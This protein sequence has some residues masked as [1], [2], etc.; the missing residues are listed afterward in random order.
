MKLSM[1]Q[2]IRMQAHCI[3]G[4]P[5]FTAYSPGPSVVNTAFTYTYHATGVG[6]TYSISSGSVPPGLTLNAS[7][8][9]LSGTP[10]AS[11]NYSFII[12]ATNAYGFDESPQL[13]STALTAMV[14]F[15]P[16]AG[17]AAS[18]TINGYNGSITSQ[19]WYINFGSGPVL[20]P[21]ATA[22]TYTPVLTGGVGNGG[23]DVGGY[24][25]VRGVTPTGTFTSLEFNTLNS[26]IR[27]GATLNTATP[28]SGGASGGSAQA[29][30]TIGAPVTLRAYDNATKYYVDQVVAPGTYNAYSSL[31]AAGL[32]GAP[33]NSQSTNV[34]YSYRN[35]QGP[36]AVIAPKADT[37]AA[38]ATRPGFNTGTGF[39]VKAG[40]LYDPNGNRFRIRGVNQC[41]YDD[42]AQGLPIAKFNA[43]RMALYLTQPWTGGGYV[44]SLVM[45]NQVTNKIMPIPSTQ[46][47]WCRFTG[48]ISGNTLTVNSKSG[49]DFGS[50]V[51]T[52]SVA[53]AGGASAFT[54]TQYGTGT[55]G[56]GTYTISGSPQTT[57]TIQFTGTATTTGNQDPAYPLACAQAWIDQAANWTTFNGQMMLNLINEWG[58]DAGNTFQGSVNGNVL[59]VSGLN[60]AHKFIHTNMTVDT[61]GLPTFTVLSAI[62]VDANGNGTWTIDQSLSQLTTVSMRDSTWRTA[63]I[64]A[65]T[66]LRAAGFTCPILI[67][68]PGGGQAITALTNGDALA[69]LKADPMQNVVFGLHVYGLYSSYEP[70]LFNSVGLQLWNAAQASLA[71]SNGLVFIIGEFGPGFAIG[72]SP[73]ILDPIEIMAVCEA[74]NLGWIPWAWDDP[75]NAVGD[76]A[77]TSLFAL[78]Q[79]AQQ[80]NYQTGVSADL[81]DFGRKC[82]EHP[83][84]GTLV[85]AQPATNF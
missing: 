16:V 85:L 52:M 28:S 24:L 41:H 60:S 4:V 82:I 18:F 68:A 36:S 50:L 35:Q 26:V 40:A 8:G 74:Y 80:G 38:T 2:L 6:V 20:I 27:G 1:Q 46:V 37:T 67:D 78:C 63:N 70:G 59:T 65:I 5:K 7:T 44:N 12:R 55:G 15:Q 73:T 56:A 21:G 62:T 72:P 54:I 10:T 19:Q 39:F 84:Y 17:K 79:H 64:T 3:S 32:T 9:V 14:T 11:G 13:I 57:G 48:S 71:T 75:S 51:K 30:I 45:G 29:S 47:V 76:S 53:A 69:V 43:N 25:S 66:N 83:V 81:T 61:A 42:P 49:S 77:Y 23:T 31:L 58:P 34:N 22:S 33:S